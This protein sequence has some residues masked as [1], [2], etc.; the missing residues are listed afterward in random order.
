MTG[1]SDLTGELTGKRL[2]LLKDALPRL[3]GESP[4]S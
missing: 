3:L 2:Q 4:A 1:F